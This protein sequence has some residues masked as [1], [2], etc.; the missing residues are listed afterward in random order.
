MLTGAVLAGG[1]SV[2]YGRNK[3]LEVFEGERLVDR[4]VGALRLHCSPVL[5]VANE[6]KLYL[7]VRA[8]LLRDVV[9]FQGPLGGIYTALLF[10]P[11]DWVAVRATD[12][13][14]FVPEVLERMLAL[15][16]G[17][18]DAVVPRL[19]EKYEPLFALYHRRCI[20]AI[21]DV[22]EGPHRNVISFYRKIRLNLLEEDQWRSVDPQGLSFRNVNTPEDWSSL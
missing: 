16:R 20:P 1:R 13:P 3:A 10:S 9:P 19:G 4:A 2:R 17:G 14:I 18:G 22:L 15:S 7:T 8:T 21:A 11:N 5:L 12:M 6:L